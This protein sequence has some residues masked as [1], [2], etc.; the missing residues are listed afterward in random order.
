VTSADSASGPPS[1]ATARASGKRAALWPGRALPG[2]RVGGTGAINVNAAIARDLTA[3]GRYRAP[4][5]AADAAQRKAAGQATRD[6]LS[7][8]QANAETALK[9][10]N[11][12]AAAISGKYHLRLLGRTNYRTLLKELFVS[13][14]NM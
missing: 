12:P 10:Q 8:R 6:L 1:C 5:L 2:L 7:V 4:E 11:K 9:R 3:D 14:F 13:F